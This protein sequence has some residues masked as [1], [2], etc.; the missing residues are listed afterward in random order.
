MSNR[1]FSGGQITTM[2][3]ATCAA[4]VMAPVGVVAAAHSSVSIADGKHPARQ[5][6][7]SSSG[8]LSVKPT[9]TTSVSGAVLALPSRPLAPFA[10]SGEQTTNQALNLAMPSTGHVVVQNVS[11][12]LSVPDNIANAGARLTYT[13]DGATQ[14]LFV[15]ATRFSPQDGGANALFGATTPTAIY[16]DPGTSVTAAALDDSAGAATFDVTLSGYTS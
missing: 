5:A 11:L 15:P 10:I 8:A 2:V 4:V 9:G 6:T 1:R 13:Q 7:V 3:V 12:Y 14:H 16:P